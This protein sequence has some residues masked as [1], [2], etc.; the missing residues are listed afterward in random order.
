MVVV[1]MRWW[2]W[3][4]N[5]EVPEDGDKIEGTHHATRTAAGHQ[6][7]L[8]SSCF[9][10]LSLSLSLSSFLSPFSSFTTDLFLTLLFHTSS[11]RS[12]HDAVPISLIAIPPVTSPTSLTPRQTRTSS[13]SARPITILHWYCL[14]KARGCAP[15]LIPD[16]SCRPFLQALSARS[17]LR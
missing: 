2:S 4:T 11:R 14:V 8:L 5:K 10:F 9:F 17:L 6:R 7:W 12:N 1:V 13:N 16:A 3:R 15:S